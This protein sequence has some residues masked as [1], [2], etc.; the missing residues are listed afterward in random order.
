M[1]HFRRQPRRT[2]QASSPRTKSD[3]VEDVRRLP[4]LPTAKPITFSAPGALFTVRKRKLR[5][6]HNV[7]QQLKLINVVDA[8]LFH[9]A[10]FLKLSF[11][12]P[13]LLFFLSLFSRLLFPLHLRFHLFDFLLDYRSVILTHSHGLRNRNKSAH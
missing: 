3:D 7:A 6:A 10:H 5:T 8:F 12:L 13:G 4:E 11:F 9:E 1:I 2:R